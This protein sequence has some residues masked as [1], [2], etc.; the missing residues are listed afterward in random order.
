MAYIDRSGHIRSSVNPTDVVRLSFPK[1]PRATS[2]YSP[3]SASAF[4]SYKQNLRLPSAHNYRATDPENPND[5]VTEALGFLPINTKYLSN[6]TNGF[7]MNS[8]ADVIF[9]TE[10]KRRRWEGTAFDVDT[11][12]GWIVNYTP[13]GWG[14]NSADL[15]WNTIIKPVLGSIQMANANK[16]DNFTFWDGLTSGLSA[17]AVNAL[18]NVGNTLDIVANPVK[19]AIIEG[20]NRD[21]WDAAWTGFQRGLIGDATYGR[22]QYDYSDYVDNFGISLLLEF[23]SDPLNAVSLGTKGLI[24]AAAKGG[25]GLIDDAVGVVADTITIASKNAT[26]EVGQE[27]AENVMKG[28]TKEVVETTVPEFNE[29]VAKTVAKDFTETATTDIVKSSTAQKEIT[30]YILDNQEDAVKT[31]T[32]A[33]KNNNFKITEDAVEHMLEFITKGDKPVLEALQDFAKAA[34]SSASSVLSRLAKDPALAKKLLNETTEVSKLK[35]LLAIPELNKLPDDIGEALYRQL[36]TNKSLRSAAA[37]WAGFKDWTPSTQQF[38]AEALQDLKLVDL[39]SIARLSKLYGNAELVEAFLRNI[40]LRSTGIDLLAKGGTKLVGKGLGYLNNYKANK[41]S[42]TVRNVSDWLQ[43]NNPDY[44]V[45]F[46][47]HGKVVRVKATADV[48]GKAPIKKPVSFKVTTLERLDKILNEQR[49]MLL[50]KSFSIATL[51]VDI[52]Q[53]IYYDALDAI[54]SVIATDSTFKRL[55][56]NNLKNLVDYLNN[57]EIN[58]EAIKRFVNKLNDTYAHL[59]KPVTKS[60]LDAYTQALKEL[61]ALAEYEG[62]SSVTDNLKI[63]N[64][65]SESAIS[66]NITKERYEAARRVGYEI[67]KQTK[68]LTDLKKLDDF[69]SPK[70]YAAL[71]VAA[72]NLTELNF[73]TRIKEI[74]K[75][76][77]ATYIGYPGTPAKIAL[78]GET[79][80]EFFAA[81]EYYNYCKKLIDDTT[82]ADEKLINELALTDAAVKLA[83]AYDNLHNR[84]NK[85]DFTVDAF[86]QVSNV[87][88]NTLKGYVQSL[89]ELPKEVFA[90][91]ARFNSVDVD[92]ITD[93]QLVGYVL[94]LSKRGI[95]RSLFDGTNEDAKVF[96]AL[97]DDFDMGKASTVRKFLEQSF[98]DDKTQSLY[99]VEFQDAYKLLERLSNT[100]KL[101]REIEATLSV[102]LDPQH[103]E[104][105]LD[106]F[107]SKG[108]ETPNALLPENL[109]RTIEECFKSAEVKLDTILDVPKWT[110]DY[111]IA[112]IILKYTEGPNAVELSSELTSIQKAAIDAL[113][114][115]RQFAHDSLT[116]IENWV[117]AFIKLDK[118]N[119]AKLKTLTQDGRYI[120][121]LDIETTGLLTHPSAGIYQIAAKVIDAEGNQMLAPIKLRVPVKDIPDTAVLNKLFKSAD[122]KELEALKKHLD[123]D[124]LSAVEWF[125]HTYIDCDHPF[126]DTEWLDQKDITTK[127]AL[128]RLWEY[129]NEAQELSKDK[130]APVIAGHNIKEFDIV[131]LSKKAYGNTA[132]KHF[133]NKANT[134]GRV[135]DTFDT[136]QHAHHW[137]VGSTLINSYMTQ[138]AH[139]ISTID[140]PNNVVHQSV[141][142]FSDIEKLSTIK[143]ILKNED[144]YITVPDTATKVTKE[145]FTNADKLEAFNDLNESC[146]NMR[147][148]LHDP[149]FKNPQGYTYTEFKAFADRYSRACDNLFDCI[150][151]LNTT[152]KTARAVLNNSAVYNAVF[153]A[154]VLDSESF[155]TY[156]KKHFEESLFESVEDTKDKILKKLKNVLEEN[157][158]EAEAV[159]NK[160]SDLIQTITDAVAK[161]AS[162]AKAFVGTSEEVADFINDAIEEA[163]DLWR[164]VSRFKGASRVYTISKA[165]LGPEG[166]LKLW[167]DGLIDIPGWRNI[168]SVLLHNTDARDLVLL[169]PHTVYSYV[170]ENLY[171]K[172]LVKKIYG[173]GAKKCVP[174]KVLKELTENAKHIDRVK[175]GI[176]NSYITH[177]YD[178][179]YTIL[180]KVK[181]LKETSLLKQ[182]YLFDLD[183]IDLDELPKANVIAYTV[184]NYKKLVKFF[185]QQK[186]AVILDALKKFESFDRLHAAVPEAL[187]ESE[188]NA[189]HLVRSTKTIHGLK[190]DS[191][192]NLV[193]IFTGKCG[194]R[195]DVLRAVDASEA[196]AEAVLHA[197]LQ[198][199]SDHH[200]HTATSQANASLHREASAWQHR[201]D[202]LFKNVTPM[203]RDR[204]LKQINEVDVV[205][206]KAQLDQFLNRPD[207][208]ERFIEEARLS[209]GRKAFFSEEEVDL[210]AFREKGIITKVVHKT[211]EDGTSGYLHL[212]GVPVT[213]MQDILLLNNE[214]SPDILKELSDLKIIVEATTIKEGDTTLYKYVLNE[215][216]ELSEE[217]TDAKIIT[218]INID[219]DLKRLVSEWRARD[220]A[221]VKNIGYSNGDILH[222]D[223]ITSFDKLLGVDSKKLI[224]VETL[225]SVG[226]FDDLKANNLVIGNRAVQA[227]FNE[228]ACSDFIRRHAYN[229]VNY[230]DTQLSNVVRYLNMLCNNENGIDTGWLKNLNDKDLYEALKNNKDFT[231]VYV[232]PSKKF[233]QTAS[234]LVVE[235]LSVVNVESIKIARKLNAHVVPTYSAY[236]MIQAVNTFKLPRLLHIVQGLSTLYKVGYLSSVGWLVRNFIDS[237]Y[238]NHLDFKDTMSIHTQI[239]GLFSTM[240]LV[241]DYTTVVQTV[242]R[243]FDNITEYKALYHLC[244]DTPAQ[245]AELLKNDNTL[246]HYITRFQN[247]LSD[248][249]VTKIKNHL[250]DVNL[251]EVTDLFIKNGPSAGVVR[252]IKNTIPVTNSATQK[253]VDF[254]TEKM[255][256]KLLFNTNELIEQSARLQ[257]YLYAL[258]SGA[259][260]DEAVA[261]VIKT[262]FDYSD[263]S[264]SMLY[265]EL[266]FP[267]MSFSFKNLEYWI[268]TIYSNGFIAGE[269]ENLFRCIFNYNSLFNPDYEVY[270]NYDYSFDFEKDIIGFRASQPWQ[271]INA[272]RLYHMLS[273]N[274]VWDTGKDVKYDNGYDVKDADLMSVFKLSPSV[275]DAVN[276]LYMPIDQFQQRMLPPYELLSQAITAKLTG[277]STELDASL[278]ING[279]LNKL[280]FVGAVLER[281]GLGINGP[282]KANNVVRRVEDAGLLQAVSSLFTTAYVP[283]KTYNTWYGANDEYLTTL[284]HRTYIRSPY[285]RSKYSG[286]KMNY[287]AVRYYSSYTNPYASRYRIES[288]ARNPYYKPLYSKSKRYNTR[289]TFYSSLTYNSLSENLLKKRI[290]DKHYYV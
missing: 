221:C 285:Y 26:K 46:K 86:K 200:L 173:V 170:F 62:T 7:A 276:M 41:F 176:L 164:M 106:V 111:T 210:S 103:V 225:K 190:F 78:L 252:G 35:K 197:I 150:I 16:S 198:H 28:V 193:S 218:N 160:N 122:P 89:D 196:D 215:A 137:R 146:V 159:V 113:I 289:N 126:Y 118:N 100:R 149:I 271:I 21:S 105:F 205:Y 214:L 269:M 8:I 39:P 229:T 167:Q 238:K 212:L 124:E 27:A 265:T 266:I 97:L 219:T 263:K 67:N 220:A 231:L 80:D 179:A 129:T 130:L 223:I 272:A 250:I 101:L 59:S 256:T 112:D 155:E 109:S 178:D 121:V 18:V 253:L 53:N 224:P 144:A 123:V 204:L 239:K 284:P 177:H 45:D 70:D 237:N 117:D 83:E 77:E 2:Y 88:L 147:S 260:L 6:P 248:S 208:P 138:L 227:E 102:G 180:N 37:K 270:R 98:S 61:A 279:F 206:S 209:A 32:A 188:P 251:F 139:T 158:T 245:L 287:S 192:N 22:K 142:S 74:N 290:L 17:S 143:S 58:D 242:G 202:N 48:I 261:R 33:L 195:S 4:G 255:P 136:L 235:K 278:S 114:K 275:L 286:F 73:L 254:W 259:S 34:K 161:Q 94:G 25:T 207:A 151:K 38:A 199:N 30:R 110:Q 154:T 145:L 36:S 166:F 68:R 134:D 55:K 108:L 228:Y 90:A 72:T 119:Q 57:A 85:I 230:I 264:L 277:D 24:T 226:Y 175:K 54:N 174:V 92:A 47:K 148:I 11:P 44:A 60:D 133:F 156:F 281:T 274:I 13:L 280:P 51:D 132:L 249:A 20:V 76:L 243:N 141:F 23:L 203:R 87:K 14:I 282:T 232:R 10:A 183:L 268:D 125:K 187:L 96:S 63:E 107:V 181:S 234:G 79:Y 71:S 84:L 191:N 241:M 66:K 185:E 40:A 236:T 186:D 135:F 267:F 233:S 273:G 15:S 43:K 104:C 163:T 258:Q 75:L 182:T 31:I 247:S 211:L 56:I 65:I 42:K 19:G 128:T 153:D 216:T 283:H 184:A 95:I 64:I 5:Y 3:Q 201:V 257:S 152:E 82:D 165:G 131:M 116:D 217:V 244:T 171:S 99:N 288:L 49:D 262:H 52:L 12:L 222:E 140:I 213:K 246:A 81:V 91:R 69:L 93:N 189:H 9:N 120:V 157:L 29:T 50:G 240:H 127:K 1:L 172:D 194:D 115:R 169:N 168:M 162:S